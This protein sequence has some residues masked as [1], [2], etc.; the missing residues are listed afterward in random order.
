MEKGFWNYLIDELAKLHI[1][2]S[3][4]IVLISLTSVAVGVILFAHY[5]NGLGLIV[6][7]VLIL[8]YLGYKYL[9]WRKK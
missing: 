6:F 7:P 1:I 9:E 8:I 5:T 2:V 3:T 4:V